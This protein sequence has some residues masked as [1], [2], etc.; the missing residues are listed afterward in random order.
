M[1][2]R[3]FLIVMDSLGVGEAKDAD[4]FNDVGSNTLLHTIGNHYNL[5]VLERMGLRSAPENW[6]GIWTMTTK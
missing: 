2:K 5:D 4:K 1:Y 6:S 3:M